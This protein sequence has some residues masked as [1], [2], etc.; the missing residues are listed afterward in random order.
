M[1]IT[2]TIDDEKGLDDDGGDESF[3]LENDW[4]DDEVG[5]DDDEELYP[6]EKNDDVKEGTVIK[7]IPI[8]EW[9]KTDVSEISQVEGISCTASFKNKARP[10]IR[11]E[12]TLP[13]LGFSQEEIHSFDF[14]DILIVELR[15]QDDKY[16]QIESAPPEVIVGQPMVFKDKRAGFGKANS[17]FRCY[18]EQER[19]KALSTMLDPS[20]LSWTIANRLRTQLAVWWATHEKSNKKNIMSV[21]APCHSTIRYEDVLEVMIHSLKPYCRSKKALL[22]NFSNKRLAIKELDDCKDMLNDVSNQT[23]ANFCE[24]WGIFKDFID[25][26]LLFDLVTSGNG[27]AQIAV[28]VF[29]ELMSIGLG[30]IICG[31]KISRKGFK[32]TICS[33]IACAF[34]LQECGVL[35]LD[36]EVRARGDELMMMLSLLKTACGFPERLKLCI[37]GLLGVLS[38][39]KTGLNESLV[40]SADSIAEHVKRPMGAEQVQKIRLILQSCPDL[41]ELKQLTSNGIEEMKWKLHQRHP[42]LESLLTW[43]V[44]TN[45]AHIRKL[46]SFEV[47]SKNLHLLGLNVDSVFEFCNAPV[48]KERKFQEMKKKFGSAFA[49]HGSA[50]GN[51]FSIIRNGLKNCSDGEY[52]CLKSHGAAYGPGIYLTDNSCTAMGYTIR[53]FS[54]PQNILLSPVLNAS[55]KKILAICEYIKGSDRI[56]KLTKSAIDRGI[57][58]FPNEGTVIIRYIVLFEN[59]VKRIQISEIFGSVKDVAKESYIQSKFT[60]KF[61]LKSTGV[62]M[63]NLIWSVPFYKKVSKL[64]GSLENGTENTTFEKNRNIFTLLGEPKKEA[65]DKDVTFLKEAVQR[66][67]DNLLPKKLGKVLGE[68]KLFEDCQI[69]WEAKAVKL[70]CGCK[71]SCKPC[72]SSWMK[73]KVQSKDVYPWIL[74]PSQKCMKPLKPKLL[75]SLM[76]VCSLANFVKEYLKISLIRSR[77][78]ALCANSKCSFGLINL[79]DVN[80]KTQ[81]KCHYCGT[82][83]A[84]V[85]DKDIMKLYRTG[86]MRDCPVCKFPHMRDKGMCNIMQC[87]QCQIW[88]NWKSYDCGD[89]M[90]VLKLKARNDKTLWEPG[91]LEYQRMLERTK[92][93]EFRSLLEKNGIK[94]NPNYKRGWM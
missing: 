93:E 6:W 56:R 46:D 91:E 80:K 87:G 64:V 81:I 12:F 73:S 71:M 43:V 15:F 74:C 50:M 92:P 10:M 5:W 16:F 84:A 28:I 30:C 21:F 72:L 48:L 55:R 90:A 40:Q 70:D 13:K 26:D 27:L 23:T 44:G 59:Q 83:Q 2:L 14:S 41:L 42:L 89:S 61:T 79:L 88:W 65:S 75:L 58:V 35:R 78:W 33:K 4:S 18:T 69:C 82:K 31:E 67:Y 7:G 36:K 39:E 45:R 94:Y 37:P 62:Q 22:R 9:I 17:S 57:H 76:D 77:N 11:L 8:D 38:P 19:A 54:K 24:K 85:V 66:C 86:A 34:K 51:W 3:V 25:Q 20:G 32:P 53:S 29:K 1:S 60:L 63:D 49:F 68:F 52:K 47:K